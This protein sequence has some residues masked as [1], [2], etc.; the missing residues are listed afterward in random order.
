VA[1]QAVRWTRPPGWRTPPGV[2]ESLDKNTL[3]P[4][5]AGVFFF[6][7]TAGDARGVMK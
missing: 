2:S 1:L 3:V 7:G 4:A 5:G 6:A